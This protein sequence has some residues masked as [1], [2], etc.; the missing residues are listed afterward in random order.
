MNPLLLLLAFACSGGPTSGKQALW[1]VSQQLTY[2]SV[3]SIGPH[4]TEAT[5]VHE[6][7]GDRPRKTTEVFDVRWGDWDNFQ[8]RRSRN[9]KLLM[10]HR[11]IQGVPYGRSGRSDFH[12]SSDAELFRVELSQTW[13]SFGL[14]L[15]PFQWQ[16]SAEPDGDA[17]VEGRP[18]RRYVLSLAELPEGT[19]QRGHVPVSLEGTIVLDAATGVRLIA[20]V[21]GRYLEQGRADREWTTRYRLT[22]SGFGIPP[23]LLKPQGVE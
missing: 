1:D 21:E 12:E 20:E 23:D 5:A 2:A 8:I 4:H 13:N 16:M 18:A 19:P 6:R 7:S 15:E 3:A 11:V 14:A 22:R 17:I 10:E 9:G